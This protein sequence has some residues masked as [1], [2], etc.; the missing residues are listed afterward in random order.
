MVLDG[1]T[2]DMSGPMTAK[3]IQRFVESVRV[4]VVDL[5]GDGTREVLAQAPW[6]PLCGATGNC[7]FWVFEFANGRMRVILDNGKFGN[8]FEKVIVRPWYTN[9]YKDIVL[10]AHDSASERSLAVYQ[11]RYGKY[12]VSACYETTMIGD[13]GQFL[14]QPAVYSSKCQ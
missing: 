13:N 12:R 6:I 7:S 14:D 5:K 4:E 1:D 3:R 2:E 10:G 8:G 9:G 11:Y